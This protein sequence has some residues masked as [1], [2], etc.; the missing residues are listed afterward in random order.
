[1]NR[2]T[3]GPS[4]LRRGLIAACAI[5]GA[6]LGA[7]ATG[8]VSA[9]QSVAVVE[10]VCDDLDTGHLSAND[11]TSFEIT[12]PDGMLIDRVCV[13]AGSAVQG[14]GPEYTPYDPPVE[15]V[16]I[17]HSTDK[18]ISHYSVSYV[19]KPDPTTST[20][21]TT[22][23]VDSTTTTTTAGST[24]TTAGGSTTTHTVGPTTPGEL[25]RTGPASSGA[26]IAGM[27][28]LAAGGAALLISRRRPA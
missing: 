28:A 20:T 13:K 23:V 1:M 9:Q 21:T 12:A 3:S 10:Q 24:T 6:S 7:I 15:E 25:P 18:E 5:V 17:S 11:E 19:P 14:D 4:R 26:V 16:T 27:A 8:T 2:T 22:T